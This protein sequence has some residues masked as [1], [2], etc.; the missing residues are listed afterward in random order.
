VPGV[1]AVTLGDFRLSGA[2]AQVNVI[3]AASP[4]LGANGLIGAELV[5][6]EPG[7]LPGVVLAS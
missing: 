3:S 5:T 4:T 7:P 6:V 2:A 1:V